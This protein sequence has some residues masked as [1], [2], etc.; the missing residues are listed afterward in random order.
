MDGCFPPYRPAYGA[1]S[2]TFK[3]NCILGMRNLVIF[4]YKIYQAAFHVINRACHYVSY[5]TSYAMASRPT[6]KP[7]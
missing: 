3:G 2:Y 4:C 6:G 1:I 7:S 5:K